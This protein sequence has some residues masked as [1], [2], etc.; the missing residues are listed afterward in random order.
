[1]QVLTLVWGGIAFTAMAIGLL[2]VLYYLNWFTVPFAGIGIILSLAALILLR[3]RREA[4]P[5]AGLT[6]SVI[7]MIVGV[8]RLRGGFGL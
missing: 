1:V 8:L 4:Y 7:A 2:P 5:L 6:C 3:G